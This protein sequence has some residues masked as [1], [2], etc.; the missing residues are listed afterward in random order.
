MLPVIN[1]RITGNIFLFKIGFQSDQ[2]DYSIF[3]RQP[4]WE[5]LFPAEQSQGVADDSYG[6]ECHC[7]GS[8]DRAQ[9]P[10]EPVIKHASRQGNADNIVNEC[11]EKVLP[12]SPHGCPA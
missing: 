3:F 1:A 2:S 6:A 10:M 8:G 4:V 9:L 7:G 5:T 12:D 11:P